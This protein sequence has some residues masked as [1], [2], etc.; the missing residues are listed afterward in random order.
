MKSE[1]APAIASEAVNIG[2]SR[3]AGER[4]Q[5][6]I[7]P[8]MHLVGVEVHPNRDQAVGKHPGRCD[9]D[10]YRPANQIDCVGVCC[11]A[12]SHRYR[13]LEPVHPDWWILEQID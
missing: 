11:C 9:S 1:A 13:T 7:K 12:V 4:T 6:G 3:R 5:A 2:E 10:V 8:G